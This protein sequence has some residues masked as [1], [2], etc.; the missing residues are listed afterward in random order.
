MSVFF[1]Q[2]DL[3]KKIPSIVSND[4]EELQNERMHSGVA[5]T[6]DETSNLF[7]AS[8]SV[9]WVA[10]TVVVQLPVPPLRVLLKPS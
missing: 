10:V 3:W 7:A 2:T 4:I 5:T 6:P 1:D 9:A 8:L